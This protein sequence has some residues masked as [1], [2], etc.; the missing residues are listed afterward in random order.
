VV[1]AVSLLCCLSVA[2]LE[3]RAAGVHCVVKTGLGVVTVCGSE[4]QW[5]AGR[6]EQREASTSVHVW[7]RHCT[8]TTGL[9]A[10]ASSIC[11]VPSATARGQLPSRSTS[12]SSISAQEISCIAGSGAPQR[13]AYVP[14]VTPSR[15]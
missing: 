2:A 10:T 5:E 9:D 4:R 14:A 7:P 8:A 15:A 3:S 1:R 13:Q 6:A 11:T 12:M